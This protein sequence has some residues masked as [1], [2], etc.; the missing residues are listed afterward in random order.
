MSSSV[1]ILAFSAAHAF[2]VLFHLLVLILFL[3]HILILVQGA[4]GLWA[5]V[6][7]AVMALWVPIGGI[8]HSLIGLGTVILLCRIGVL[9]IAVLLI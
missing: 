5:L 9:H 3:A 6:L 7:L 4:V 1:V 8:T 2:L